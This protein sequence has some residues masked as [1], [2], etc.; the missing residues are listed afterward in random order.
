VNIDDAWQLI[1]DCTKGGDWYGVL[2][3][4][5]AL[6]EAGEEDTA[7]GIRWAIHN[8]YQPKE[9]L[10]D[11]S[12]RG[13]CFFFSYGSKGSSLVHHGFRHENSIEVWKELLKVRQKGLEFWT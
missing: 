13:Y 9:T 2:V 7:I 5:D 1:A 12:V 6:Q 8:N 11:V 4:A 3:G 10:V